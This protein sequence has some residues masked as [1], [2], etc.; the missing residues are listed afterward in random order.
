M[1]MSLIIAFAALA[2]SVVPPQ[3]AYAQDPEAGC[4]GIVGNALGSAQQ[5]WK[6]ECS[7]QDLACAELGT[8]FLRFFDAPTCVEA[9]AN[10]ELHGLLTD[11]ATQNAASKADE[12]SHIA[13]VGCTAIA[14]CGFCGAALALGICPTFCM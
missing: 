6:S 14:Q 12:A 2:T 11:A 4:N 9:L 10:G 5:C 8:A 7:P 3:Q 13:E 1:K